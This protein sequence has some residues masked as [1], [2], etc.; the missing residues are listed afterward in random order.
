M[1][2][3]R[4]L[5]SNWPKVDTCATQARQAQRGFTLIE[6]MIAIVLGMLIMVALTTLLVNIT[7]NNSEMAKTNAQIENGRFSIQ[8]LGGDIVHGGFWGGYVP[9][10][11]DITIPAVDYD[12]ATMAPT[13]V[14]APCLAYSAAN[15]TTAYKNSLIAIPVQS[16]EGVPAGCEAVVTNQQANTDVLVVRHIATCSPGMDNC[17]TVLESANKL[18]FQIPQCQHEISAYAQAATATTIT[19]S[20]RES[21]VNDVYNG[22]TIHI[23]SGPGAGQSRVILSYDGATKQAT[24]T[25]AWGV[26]PDSKSVYNSGNYVLDTSGFSFTQRNCA[27]QAE[28][29]KFI[30][31]IYYVRDFAI[32]AGDRI[33]TL[34]RSQFDLSDGVLEHKPAVA[35]IEGIQGFRVEL[36]IDDIGKAGTL[37]NYTQGAVWADPTNLVT[38]QNRGDGIPDGAFVRCT[39]ARPCT[40]QQLANVTAVKLYVLARNRERTAGYND[41]KT[42]TLGIAEQGPFG[43]D[44]KRHVFSTTVRLINISGRRETPP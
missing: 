13:V 2:L 22:R 33:P 8:L 14:P 36:G 5:S 21:A 39:T 37:V 18:Y 12:G 20:P 29:R 26:I 43:D 7:R 17:E 34:V 27:T 44:F 42:Y 38:L 35:L 10:F 40:A 28:R 19:L 31:T 9:Q 41:G 16:Y 24:L 4:T 1:T 32:T 6:L 3:H 15:W 11:D 30:S 23:I 25:A